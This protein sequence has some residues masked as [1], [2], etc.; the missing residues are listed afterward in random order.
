MVA[1]FSLSKVYCWSLN[2]CRCVVPVPKLKK[3]AILVLKLCL[4]LIFI[5]MGLDPHVRS[6][7]HLSPL[8]W[9]GSARRCAAV[10]CGCSPMHL[11]GSGVGAR[12]HACAWQ[13]LA[14]TS[15]RTSHELYSNFYDV[16]FCLTQ[17]AR[18]NVTT[19]LETS[20]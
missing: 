13:L 12:P 1:Y 4:G 5:Q 3:Y 6:I 15:L 16:S 7:S 19:L 10:Q 18:I 9:Q 20:N 17:R 11:C 14:S 2:L 8:S